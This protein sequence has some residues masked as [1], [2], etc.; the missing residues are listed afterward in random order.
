VRDDAPVRRGLVVCCLVGFAAGLAALRIATA[1]P[2]FSFAGT[3]WVDALVLLGAGWSLIAGGIVLAA[4]RPRST[5]AVALA[6]TGVC[7]FLA[8][9]DSPGVD[10]SLLFTAGL[11]L[12]TSCPV[13][14]TWLMFAYP[15]GRLET[16]RERAA[17]IVAAG[18]G[19]A[20]GVLPALWFRPASAGCRSCSENLASIW[21]DPDATTEVT[22]LGLRLAI[23]AAVA[24]IA[25]G[26]WRL[27]RA[28]PARRRLDAP[29]IVPGCAY[30]V[31]VSW[32][33]A[34]SIER[35][36]VTTGGTEHR[37][38]I[39]QAIA[40]IALGGGVIV[41]EVRIR[42]TRSSVARLV[43]HLDEA[44]GG[45]RIRDTLARS[46]RT[47][48]LEL[49]YPLGE[50]R[51]VDAEG[52]PVVLPPPA[53]WSA[54]PL[55]YD[56]DHTAA[57][58]VHRPG[59][60]D[61]SAA[62]EEIANVAQLALDNERLRAELRAQ[63]LDLRASRTRIV[64]TGDA[65]RRRLER[66]LHDGAQQR[67]V[68]LLMAARLARATAAA[69]VGPATLACLDRIGGDLQS[70]IDELR[71]IAEGIH[72]AVLSY[73]GLG[74]ALDSLADGASLEVGSVPSGRFAVAVENAAYRVVAEAARTGPTRVIA[75]RREDVLVVDVDTVTPP[76]SVMVDL[77]DRVGAANGSIAVTEV[78]GNRVAVRVELPC[79]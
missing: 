37:L 72:P 49:I 57:V 75:S 68:G 56:G 65:E 19:V 60:L 38:W 20:V 48:D 44:V 41:T 62:V 63:E 53:G 10:S 5:V 40:L 24:A 70:A 77:Q 30:L 31:A 52:R 55:V 16:G 67:L 9:F 23:A 79:G 28:S 61:D 42:R 18:A 51:Y 17:V 11:L 25:C 58:L 13:L 7:W 33:Y 66:D 73:A 8:E 32:T 43:V 59:L 36:F 4:R 29:I 26:A 1:N 12:A 74:P 47:A 14:V 22:R 69:G 6:V 21:D 54:T 71:D 50:G 3:S 64:E 76:G 34:L 46:L 2:A 35:G 39:A 78:A 45:A 27:A 15:D